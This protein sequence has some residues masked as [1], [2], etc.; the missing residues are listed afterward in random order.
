VWN[1]P[2]T[3]YSG[4]PIKEKFRNGQQNQDGGSSPSVEFTK[5]NA[6]FRNSGMDPAMNKAQLFY[7]NS[8]WGLLGPDDPPLRVNTY[9]GHVWNV[10]VDDET[11]KTIVIDEKDGPEQD[12]SI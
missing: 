8:Y 7:E 9:Q 12:F 4:S 6:S 10:K 11:V 3:G 1:T 2:R 5:I